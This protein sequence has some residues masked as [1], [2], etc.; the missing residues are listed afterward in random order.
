MAQV[1]FSDARES[2]DFSDLLESDEENDDS[3]V[4]DLMQTQE[5]CLLLFLVLQM[6]R[7]AV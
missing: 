6:Q 5:S 2:V 4:A 7:K 1:I 3:Y